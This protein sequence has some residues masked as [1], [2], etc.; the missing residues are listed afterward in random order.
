MVDVRLVRGP[1]IRS[2][3]LLHCD[4]RQRSRAHKRV[5]FVL[6]LVFYPHTS[7]SAIGL[8]PEV[9]FGC[10]GAAKLEADEVI[11]FIV[12]GESAPLIGV[13]RGELFDF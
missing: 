11:F 8:R 9:R 12:F 13:T 7:C 3:H 5:Q 2:D 1:P 10:R 4:Q 6:Q